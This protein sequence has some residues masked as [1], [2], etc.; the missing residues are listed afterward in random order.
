MSTES[1]EHHGYSPGERAILRAIEELNQREEELMATV[2]ELTAALNQVK[3]DLEAQTGASRAEFTKLEG[4]LTNKGIDP[5]ELDSI[6]ASLE[7]LDNA[8]KGIVVPTT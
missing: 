4:E 7:G 3:G 1:G 8:V 6:K 5:A 2:E